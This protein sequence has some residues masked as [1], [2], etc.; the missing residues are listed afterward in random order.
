M[1]KKKPK[2]KRYWVH[3]GYTI[4]HSVVVEAKNEE[5]AEKIAID[6]YEVTSLCCQC[7]QQLQGDLTLEEVEVEEASPEEPLT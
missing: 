7:A 4:G 5:D 1:S 3:I 2:L 6:K